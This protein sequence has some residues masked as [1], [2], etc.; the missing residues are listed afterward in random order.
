MVTEDYSKEPYKCGYNLHFS[1]LLYSV[2]SWR[3]KFGSNQEQFYNFIREDLIHPETILER[4]DKVEEI[5]GTKGFG[6]KKVKSVLS[7]AQHWNEVAP[8]RRVREDT[9]FTQATPIRKDICD[10]FYGVG[11]KFA[12][13]FLR[14]SGYPNVAPIDSNAMIYIEHRLGF[15]N[16]N[17]R[18]GLRFNQHLTYENILDEDAKAHGKNLA[19]HQATIYATLSTWKKDMN[20]IPADEPDPWSPVPQYHQDTR[21]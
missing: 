17:A 15:H 10:A 1:A 13:L 18:S 7:M 20:I 14:M 16:R 21:E 3:E 19:L 9:H 8:T 2:L 11:I 12:S 4:K 5:L 6:T